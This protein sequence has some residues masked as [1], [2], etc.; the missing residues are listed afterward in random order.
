[1]WSLDVHSSLGKVVAL[2]LHAVPNLGT[3]LSK[4]DSS[5]W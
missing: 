4:S 5:G 1:M 2:W 3:E